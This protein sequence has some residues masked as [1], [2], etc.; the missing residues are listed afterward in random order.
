MRW[1]KK[2]LL[3]ASVGYWGVATAAAQT[4]GPSAG[5][6]GLHRPQPLPDTADPGLVQA[7]MVQR[8]PAFII[9]AQMEEPKDRFLPGSADGLVDARGKAA[10]QFEPE[11]VKSGST[12]A[13]PVDN[14]AF[15]PPP[16]RPFFRPF[17]SYVNASKNAGCCT[18]SIVVYDNTPGNFFDGPGTVPRLWA[19]AEY[20]NWWTKG[21]N[22]PILVTTGPATGDE[23]FRGT[24]GANGTTPIV[25]GS[26]TSTGPTSGGR[27]TAGWNFDPCGNCGIEA[28]FFFLG[29]KID[30]FL[31]SSAQFPVL[32]RPF[33]NVNTGMQDRELTASPGLLP[34]DFFKL[35]SAITVQNFTDLWGIEVNYRRLF[36]SD[37]NYSVSGLLGFRYLD[38]HEGLSIT[39]NV[40]SLQAVPGFPIFDPGNQIM[41]ADSFQTRN[42]FYGG[43][44]GLD[45]EYSRGRWFV[46]G[47]VQVGLG[48][49]H[50]TI[51]IG[52]S[53]T[54]TTPAG[55]RTTFNG[56]LLALPSNS[57]SFSQ[58][59]FAVVPQVGVKLGYNLTDNVRV[60]AGYDFLYW[61]NVVRPG[62]QVDTNLNVSQIPNFGNNPAFVPPSNI[63][64]PIV[65]FRT[66]SFYAHGVS[67]GIEVRY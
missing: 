40:L 31:A 9:R 5:S 53:Q 44:I 28:S 55:Q 29:S 64:R 50:E 15:N 2:S 10:A 20:L 12:D 63:V 42:R 16:P 62:D 11:P 57:G 51:D 67:A 66:S 13:P 19:R 59:K 37:C 41:V 22:L 43:Q 39:E 6:V 21:F 17:G 34:A 3:W 4:G 18:E 54:V 49:T 60:F 65:P 27:F 24:L 36:C 38:L 47:R 35:Q 30:T 46:G 8:A 61:S 56:G 48:V 23:N 33:F 45:G 1:F 52:G 26:T 7:G 14:M 25:G 58:N 32:A